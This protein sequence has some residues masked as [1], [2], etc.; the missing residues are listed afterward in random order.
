MPAEITRRPAYRAGLPSLSLRVEYSGPKPR[1]RVDAEGF[2]H[3]R[4]RAQTINVRVVELPLSGDLA[5][6]FGEDKNKDGML[7]AAVIESFTIQ[8]SSS[9]GM[10]TRRDGGVSEMPMPPIGEREFHLYQPTWPLEISDGQESIIWGVFV[11]EPEGA[12]E[13][14][15]L[16]ERVQHAEAAWLFK[17]ST[18][19][20][21]QK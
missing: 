15:T 11:G 9:S 20:T 10:V 3:G 21:P 17:V 4:S 16:T 14:T 12:K 13:N 8:S 6:A 7:L 19:D 1:L 18:T 5:F 2:E